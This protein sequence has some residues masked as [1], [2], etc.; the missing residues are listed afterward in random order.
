MCPSSPRAE[1]QPRPHPRGADRRRGQR[2]AGWR[3]P[4]STSSI[5]RFPKSRAFCASA[6]NGA[7]VT[8]ASEVPR[9]ALMSQVQRLVVKIGS[10]TLTTQSRKLDDEVVTQ[11]VEDV[12][13]LRS[14][15]LEVAIVTSGAVAAGHGAVGTGQTPGQ[16]RPTTSPRGHRPSP[17]DGISTRTNSAAEACPSAK[18]F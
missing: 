13:E 12:V 11:L 2:R 10:S 5:T 14:Q 8:E 7:P 4:S 17:V 9:Q 18:C 3:P 6:G 1:R 16:H 15:G